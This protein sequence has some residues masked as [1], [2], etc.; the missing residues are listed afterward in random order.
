MKL[1]RILMLGFVVA[2]CTSTQAPV[3]PPNSPSFSKI[4]STSGFKSPQFEITM[5][6]AQRPG[7]V[8]ITYAPTRTLFAWWPLSL[9]VPPKQVRWILLA[10]S[11]F[12]DD[13][14]ATLNHIRTHSAD[15]RWSAW[16]DYRPG[17][18]EGTSGTPLPWPTVAM[19]SSSRVAR[20]RA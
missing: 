3:E 5:P 13:F 18:G 14:S 17:S 8:P 19:C 12:G 10:A 6:V 1:L 4:G 16:L 15:P 11:E 9:D 20:C 2:A 7:N